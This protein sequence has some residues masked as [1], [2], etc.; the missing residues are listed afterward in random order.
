MVVRMRSTRSHTGNRRSHHALKSPDLA[1]CKNCGGH[2][3]PHHMCLECGF[4]KGRIVIDIKAQK[5]A[6]AARLQAKKDMIA[7]QTA[8]AANVAPATDESPIENPS[9]EKAIDAP[10]KTDVK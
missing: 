2:Y 3:K 1:V 7:S 10:A 4:Y 9:D 8:Q 6:R 5:A